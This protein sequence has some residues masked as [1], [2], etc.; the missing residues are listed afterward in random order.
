M[1]DVEPDTVGVM[2]REE[3]GEGL[4]VDDFVPLLD[5]LVDEEKDG[6]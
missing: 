4:L 1:K 6:E 3:P 2:E 5:K